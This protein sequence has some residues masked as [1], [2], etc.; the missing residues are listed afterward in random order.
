MSSQYTALRVESAEQLAAV[1]EEGFLID[2]NGLVGFYCPNIVRFR[3]DKRDQG[4]FVNSGPSSLRRAALPA[5][6]YVPSALVKEAR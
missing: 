4:W 5:V 1:P 2:D 3:G 6:A